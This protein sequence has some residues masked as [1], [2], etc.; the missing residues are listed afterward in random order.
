MVLDEPT[1]GL[2]LADVSALLV[3]L[4]DLAA[5]GDAIVVIEH[6]LGLLAA[7][8]RLLELGPGGG[9]AGGRVIASGSPSALAEN[10]ESVT[11]PWLAQEFA[12]GR[13]DAV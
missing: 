13:R 12:A 3:V 1:R 11:G 8:D 4:Q 5:R 2:H 7:C 10:P 6:H 9:E